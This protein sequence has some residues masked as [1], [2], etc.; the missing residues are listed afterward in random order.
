M[1]IL[2]AEDD[3]I[4]LET[5]KEQLKKDAYT[6]LGTND[7]R[8]ALQALESFEP[9][10][11]ITDILMPYTS[12]LELIG[13]IRSGK[14]EK[15]PILVLSALDEEATVLEAF[16]LGANDFLSKPFNPAEFNIRVKRLL[17]AAKK[18]RGA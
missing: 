10:L 16:S 4:M 14:S 11:I 8:E 1:K 3:P 7:G 12:G 18:A 6:I 9:D 13:L 17:N 5:I 2:I 15:I